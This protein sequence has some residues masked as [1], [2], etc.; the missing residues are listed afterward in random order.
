MDDMDDVIAD[1]LVECVENLDRFEQDLLA[2]EERP[3]DAEL[4]DSLFRAIHTIKGSAGFLEMT[5]LATET[6][7]G[8]SL[9]SHSCRAAATAPA[10]A[11]SSSPPW[12][13][14][15]RDTR[16]AGALRGGNLLPLLNRIGLAST[17][18]SR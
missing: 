3:T 5:N 7:A 15:A 18:W 2:L 8:E 1:F 10:A 11:V 12:P 17:V 6:H 13:E 4:L 16:E 14:G 9:L